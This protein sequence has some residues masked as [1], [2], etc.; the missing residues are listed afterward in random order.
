MIADFATGGKIDLSRIEADGNEANGDTA[1]TFGTGDCTSA[2]GDPRV[3]DFGD[4]RQGVYLDI[5]CDK[6]SD[7]FTAVYADHALM[8]ADFVL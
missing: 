3:V 1:F 2:A 5:N 8:A 6:N 4:G 7:L